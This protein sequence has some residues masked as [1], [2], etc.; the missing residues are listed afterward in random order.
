M[1]SSFLQKP[2]P[3]FIANVD[4]LQW[5]TVVLPVRWQR[6]LP[7]PFV[8]R[9]YYKTCSLERYKKISHVEEFLADPRPS[10][11]EGTPRSS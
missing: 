1:I 5:A 6:L 9:N 2:N 11:G 4:T 10:K 8:C 7:N 3:T